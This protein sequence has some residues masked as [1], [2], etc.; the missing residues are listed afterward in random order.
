[1]IYLQLYWSF[2]K[3][4]LF[5][6][7]GGYASLPLIEKEVVELHNWITMTEFTDIIT[8]SQ[9]TPGPVAINTSTFVGTQIGGL[10]GAIVAT[11]GCVTP[12]FIIVLL[13]AYIYV[14]YKNVTIVSDILF[15]LRPAVVSLIGVAGL[16]IVMLA[17]FGEKKLNI[18]NL[19]FDKFG[20]HL[21]IENLTVNCIAILFFSIGFF[22]LRRYKINPIYVMVGS[23]VAGAIIYNILGV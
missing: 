6:I 13:L 15:G 8:I 17:F 22:F 9:M 20:V 7:G 19:Y 5:S 4:G 3:I 1:V 14:K 18:S 23:G 21:T 12:S 11:L 2:F 16:S 10:L